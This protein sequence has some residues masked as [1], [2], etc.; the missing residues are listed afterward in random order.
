MSA[1]SSAPSQTGE[2]LRAFCGLQVAGT[3][4]DESMAM[5]EPSANAATLP[6]Q[7]VDALPS[8]GDVRVMCYDLDSGVA[9]G[10][11]LKISA[12]QIGSIG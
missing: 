12:I 2:D 4:R 6:L 11:D 9:V 8:G 5:A 1:G 3:R 10:G 7:S